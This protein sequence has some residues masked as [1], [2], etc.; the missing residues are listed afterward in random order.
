MHKDNHNGQSEKERLNA[1]LALVADEEKPVGR[2]PDLQEI[3]AW[4]MGKLDAQRANEVKTHVARDPGCYQQWS[5]LLAEEKTAVDKPGI[6]EQVNSW[7]QAIIAGSR[8]QLTLALVASLVVAITLPLFIVEHGL[9][10]DFQ[11]GAVRGGNESEYQ[12][13]DPEVAIKGLVKKI[14]A[15]GAGVLVVRLNENKW[16][17]VITV[18]NDNKQKVIEVLSELGIKHNGQQSFRLIIK[19]K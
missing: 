10:S 19:K 3:Q 1:M 14:E 12:V 5:D 16:S 11:P 2:K 7:L 4:H 15:E 18:S 6:F 9:D 17:V 13:K 8:P